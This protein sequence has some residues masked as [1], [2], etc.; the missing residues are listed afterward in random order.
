MKY[1]IYVDHGEFEGLSPHGESGLKCTN[2]NNV[3]RQI[4]SLPAWGEWIEILDSGD[5]RCLCW[6]LPA[7][8]EWIEI[9]GM[10]FI[11]ISPGRLS[12][13][14]ESGLKFEKQRVPL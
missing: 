2:K 9:E 11:G 14:G 3:N 8:G 4:K 12:P 1:G 5:L 7:W 6:S 10:Q 13:H